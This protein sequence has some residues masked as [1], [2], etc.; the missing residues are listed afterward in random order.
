MGYNT[1]I[2]NTWLDG[3]ESTEH[4]NQCGFVA[5][6]LTPDKVQEVA[7]EMNDNTWGQVERRSTK[8]RKRTVTVDGLKISLWFAVQD[9]S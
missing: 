8:V 6:S 2:V 1:T 5:I 4:P 3:V 9:Q 7:D